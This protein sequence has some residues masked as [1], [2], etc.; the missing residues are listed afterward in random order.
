MTREEALAN[1]SSADSD[2]RLT[3]ARFFAMNASG[4]DRR[5]LRAALRKES[6]PWIKRALERSLQRAGRL[7]ETM[8]ASSVVYADPP[9]RL[10][11]ELRA[12]AIDEVA[13]TIIHELSTIVASLKL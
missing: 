4:M 11:A 12:N 10:I 5:R 9:P 2:L 6:V 13:G 7:T 8:D 1:L 3:A